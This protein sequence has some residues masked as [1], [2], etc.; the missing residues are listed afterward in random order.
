MSCDAAR[1]SRSTPSRTVSS[2]VAVARVSSTALSNG[3]S[4]RGGKRLPLQ[5]L[6]RCTQTYVQ[7]NVVFEY[8]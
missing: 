5:S 3:S 1:F 7:E 6:D 2:V 4:V 8:L